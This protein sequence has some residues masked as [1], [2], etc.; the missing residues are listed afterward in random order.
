[1]NE[2]KKCSPTCDLFK[3]GQKAIQY[4]SGNVYCRFADD[5]CE[6][7]SCKY[8]LCV[9]NKLLSNGFCGLTFKRTTSRFETQ[10]EEVVQGIKVRGKLQQRLREKE[11][12]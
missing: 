12:F 6:G 7:A 9:R 10:P 4:R 2:A 8:A 3:C 5:L 11:L 1:M